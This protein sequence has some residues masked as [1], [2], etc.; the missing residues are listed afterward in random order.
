M[1]NKRLKMCR[2]FPKLY[3]CCLEFGTYRRK[4]DVLANDRLRKDFALREHFEEKD[5]ALGE[6]FG[7]KKIALGEHFCLKTF[8]YFKKKQY[9]C[10]EF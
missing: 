10:S 3:V 2:Y 4:R 5:F 7:K 1:R 9:L 8:A 6:H